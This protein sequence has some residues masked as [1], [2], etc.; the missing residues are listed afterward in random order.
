[1]INIQ[2][3]VLATVNRI[4]HGINVPNNA[5][6]GARW[7]A[8][9][10]GRTRRIVFVRMSKLDLAEALVAAITGRFVL[11]ITKVGITRIKGRKS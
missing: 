5:A 2:E 1:M 3:L 9:G 8:G 11:V 7:K 6:I 10:S 4:G